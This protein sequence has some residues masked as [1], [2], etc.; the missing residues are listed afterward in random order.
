MTFKPLNTS[1]KY[2]QNIGQINDM[3]RQLNLE[4]QVK[5]FNGTD[6][7]PAV[8]IGRYK[9]GRYGLV[10]SDDSG[11]RRVLVGQAPDDSRPGIW[12]SI[13]G[14]DVIDELS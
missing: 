5:T 7:K 6:G 4:Q 8:T 10:I 2:G 14:V 11:F 13:D 9:Q 12:I 1:N 3:T